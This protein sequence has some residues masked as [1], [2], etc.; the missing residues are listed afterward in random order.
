MWLIP[1]LPMALAAPC[2]ESRAPF[3]VGPDGTAWRWSA[4]ARH[5]C[6]E[7]IDELGD[8]H[9]RGRWPRDDGDAEPPA[10]APLP[11][12]RML[13]ARPVPGGR[14]RLVRRSACG[15]EESLPATV[16]GAPARLVPS[17]D[18]ARVRVTVDLD[19]VLRSWSVDLSDGRVAPPTDGPFDGTVSAAVP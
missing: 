16:P 19:G 15:E 11:D 12:G 10:A 9:A 2:P 4:D 7:A 5:W 1:F 3:H 13:L 18:G 6:L 17:G 8:L 14:W